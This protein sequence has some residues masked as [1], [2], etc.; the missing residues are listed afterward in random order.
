MKAEGDDLDDAL[1]DYLDDHP[2][3]IEE[4]DSHWSE[5]MDLCQKYGFILQAFGGTATIASPATIRDSFGICELAY[6]MRINNV[7]IPTD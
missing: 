6:R 3:I 1:V 7:D 2:E 5:V 4:L